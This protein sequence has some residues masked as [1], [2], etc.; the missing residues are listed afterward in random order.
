MEQEC[1]TCFWFRYGWCDLIELEVD[2]EGCC[3]EWEGLY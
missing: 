1:S 2:E 3:E